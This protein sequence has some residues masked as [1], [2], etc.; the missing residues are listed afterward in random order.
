MGIAIPKHLVEGMN[1]YYVL[2]FPGVVFQSWWYI[3]RN[4]WPLRQETKDS[5]NATSA[6]VFFKG[7]EEGENVEDVVGVL[8]GAYKTKEGVKEPEKLEREIRMWG[9]DDPSA[10]GQLIKSDKP[11][12]D[13]TAN[14]ERT[15]QPSLSVIAR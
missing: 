13:D 8:S 7:L 1:R 3:T 15:P 12:N 9:T 5:I 4:G 14:V 6:A 2:T 10:Q 11:S